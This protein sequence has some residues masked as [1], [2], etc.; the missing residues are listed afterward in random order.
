[1][2]QPTRPYFSSRHSAGL[3]AQAVQLGHQVLVDLA[4]ENGL[5]DVHGHLVGVAQAIHE[6]GLVADFLQHIVDLRTAA[7]DDHHTN[8]HQRQ[9]DDIAHHGLA[10]FVRDHGVAAVLDHDGL[11]GKFLNIRQ[12][13][14]QSLGL[15][16]MRGHKRQ[17]L[18]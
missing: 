6:F 4:A 10:Q 13:L 17:L 15:L 9:Q 12:C 14:D 1:M 18:V 8:A 11:A 7:V 3:S 5:D 16:G 2:I